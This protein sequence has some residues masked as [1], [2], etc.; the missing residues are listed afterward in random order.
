MKRLAAILLLVAAFAARGQ[1][2]TYPFIDAHV[3]LNDPALQLALMDRHGAS[4]AIVFWGGRSSN[5]SVL[6]VARSHPD[7]FIPFAS[8]SPERDRYGAA[9]ARDDPAILEELDAMLRTGH[10]KGIGETSAV[11]FP[12]PGFPETDHPLAGA[13][14]TGIMELARRHR[15]PVIV[16]I[17]ITRLAEFGELLTRFRDVTVIW[18]HGGYTPMF[19]ARRMLER[20]PNLVYELSARTWV[21][22]PR[23]PDY[24]ILR[25]GQRVWPAWLR[26][27]EE[28]PTRFIV[29]TDASGRSAGVDDRRFATVQ[30]LLRQLSPAA[31]ERVGWRNMEELLPK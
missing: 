20:H 24:T 5:A 28:M 3:H 9:W 22:H 13:T 27:I 21:E 30:S 10:Y 15:V 31:R 23:S 2:P 19:I 4:K 14:M 1:E 18:A 16:H 25:D 29:G 6:E 8:V 26:L 12:S 17:E 7:R 11:H